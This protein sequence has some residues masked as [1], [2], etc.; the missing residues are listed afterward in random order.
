MSSSPI[1]ASPRGV[2]AVAQRASRALDVVAVLA[3]IPGWFV[4]LPVTTVA[5]ARAIRSRRKVASWARKGFITSTTVF[6]LLTPLWVA[7]AWMPSSDGLSFGRAGDVVFGVTL[8]ALWFAPFVACLGA[9]WRARRAVRLRPVRVERIDV[10]RSDAAQRVEKA[11]TRLA[12]LA[13]T[14][15][16]YRF[17]T[18]PVTDRI[19]AVVAEMNELIRRLRAKGS[20]QQLRLAT[21]QYADTLDKVVLCVSPD[22]LKDVIDNPR[23]WHQPDARVAEVHQALDAVCAQI[24][25]NIRQVNARADLDFQVALTQLTAITDDSEFARLYEGN[26]R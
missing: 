2:A 17:G 22:Y 20:P 5:T 1:P 15:Q 4:M 14:Y 10:D 16:G 25:D 12:A 11:L 23:L 6:A 18:V 21:A 3:G 13:P 19:N 26:A 24:V 8:T 7:V 9:L